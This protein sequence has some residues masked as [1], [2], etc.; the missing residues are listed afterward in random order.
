[1]QIVELSSFV[2]ETRQRGKWH[3]DS[4]LFA[5]GLYG[6]KKRK[7]KERKHR[8]KKRFSLIRECHI[9]NTLHTR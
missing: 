3:Y 1:M 7:N 4:N 2:G 5:H 8:G 9:Y 6:S